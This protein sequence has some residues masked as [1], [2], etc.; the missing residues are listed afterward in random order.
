M[1]NP[2]HP[3]KTLTAKQLED[4]YIEHLHLKFK[5]TRTEAHSASG[6]VDDDFLLSDDDHPYDDRRDNYPFPR[7]F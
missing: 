2:L 3:P 1:K 4:L 5:A 7:R 6:T